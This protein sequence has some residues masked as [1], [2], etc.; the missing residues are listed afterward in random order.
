MIHVAHR[1]LV[2]DDLPDAADSM[3][4]LLYLCGYDADAQVSGDAALV[5]VRDRRPDIVVLDIRM[6]RM[7]GFEFVRRLREIEGCER[8]PVIIVSG[9]NI[10]ESRA[11]AREL[12]IDHFFTK[13]VELKQLLKVM[14]S[15]LDSAAH[16]CAES[17]SRNAPAPPAGRFIEPYPR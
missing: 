10:A 15:L 2:V 9:S 5:S 13:P 7:D 1:V 12:G 11:R 16:D 8:T 17:A 14:E 4:S 6:P 3:A